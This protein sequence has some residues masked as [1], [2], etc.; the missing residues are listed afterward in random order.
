MKRG[1]WWVV[2]G[3]VLVALAALGWWG[4]VQ[5]R[6]FEAL[7]RAGR[8]D[9]SAG[10]QALAA[11]E[12][13]TARAAF[14]QA[15]TEFT[16]ARELLG[17][18]WLRSVPWVGRQ[19]D[20]ADDLTVIGAEGSA[21]GGQAAALLEAATR[22]DG[23]N[24][25][26]QLIS[27]APTHLE[28]ALSSLVTVAGLTDQLST[29]GLVPPLADAVDKVQQQV[30]PLAPVLERSPAM[31]ALTRHLFGA[32]HQFLVVTQNSSELRPTGGFMGTYGLLRLGPDGVEVGKFADV[33]SLPK[34]TLDL[35]LPE[36]GQVNTTHFYFRN[37]NWWMDFP[38]SARTM[39]QLW[40]NME[41]PAVDGVIAVD[42][43]LLQQL[44]R[45]YGP[46]TV[47]Q[48]RTPITAENAMN[49]LNDVVQFQSRANDGWYDRK[50]TIVA[51]VDELLGRVTR[52]SDE[53]VRPTLDAL[54]QAAA[55]KHVQVFLTDPAAQ[56][57][58]QQVGWSG[59]L[60]PPPGTTDLVAVSNG[61]IKPSKANAGVTKTLDYRV[62]LAAYGSATT[63]LELGY[64]KSRLTQ[65]GV[66]QQWLANYVRVHRAAGTTTK[67]AS[68]TGF[69]GLAD[70]TGLP[71]FGR[72]FRLDRGASASVTL[73]TE[74]PHALRQDGAGSSYRL[75]LAKQADLVDTDA[76][77]TVRAPQ[78]WSVAS[79]SAR[80][81]VDGKVL[82]TSVVGNAVTVR[83][84]LAQDLLVDVVLVRG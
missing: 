56:A 83:T 37:A 40:Q 35:P 51:L 38:T 48:T 9:A 69:T 18:A 6:Q 81:R 79:A 70:A 55:E 5:A 30:A 59:A 28:S 7:A 65:R 23:D 82:D 53:Q 64:A 80:F 24:R 58:L 47:P 52:M 42:I 72:Y 26:N 68:G 57:A 12:P 25:L 39:L 62:Q 66:P 1:A 11:G 73:R 8:D 41:Q 84:P 3:V 14:D 15:R 21:A 78:G 75:L 2:A 77:V 74:V 32:Q 54:A 50:L 34:D 19:L 60:D 36:G 49:L 27:L 20:A 44:L 31:L 67:D 10:L 43:P 45:V 13:A 61:V 22:L 16:G 46:V 17:P 76:T 29:E 4:Y 71:T 33:Y 63:S